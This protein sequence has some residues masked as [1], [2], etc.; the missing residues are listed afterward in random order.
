MMYLSLLCLPLVWQSLSIA[1]CTAANAFGTPGGVKYMTRDDV[2]PQWLDIS[3]AGGMLLLLAIDSTGASIVKENSRKF[4]ETA[5]PHNCC[6]HV[7]VH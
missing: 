7:P 2:M 4:L 5:A 6:S 1:V 3:L